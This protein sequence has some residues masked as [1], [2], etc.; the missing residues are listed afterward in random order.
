M[1]R[2]IDAGAFGTTKEITETLAGVT[3]MRERVVRL[4]TW[5][6]PPQVFR[7]FVSALLLPLAIFILTRV[8][9]D[10]I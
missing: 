1:G 2:R 6:W 8:I 9:A 5:P 4:P 7:G 3:L 10:L